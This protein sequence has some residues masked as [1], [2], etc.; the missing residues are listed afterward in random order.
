[1]KL[2]RQ[3]QKKVRFEAKFFM[4][5][6]LIVLISFFLIRF[7]AREISNSVQ[8]NRYKVNT[9]DEQVIY[10]G[11]SHNIKDD[12]NLLIKPSR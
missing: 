4:I 6:I 10:K 8:K 1:M 12:V 2:I 11:S 3:L 7:I 9:T 5:L